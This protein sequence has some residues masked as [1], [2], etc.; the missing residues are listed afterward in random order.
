MPVGTISSSPDTVGVSVVNYRVPICESYEEVLEN[1]KKIAATI[2][3]LKVG[4]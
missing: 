3:G 4:Q 2:K 1:C